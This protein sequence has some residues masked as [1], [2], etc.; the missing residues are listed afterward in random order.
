MLLAIDVGN[1]ETV[2]GVFRGEELAAHWRLSSTSPRTTDEV[3]ILFRQWAAE[4]NVVL[5]DMRGCVIS[6]VVPS[7]TGVFAEMARQAFSTEPVIIDSETETGL[8]VR[9][10]SPRT[11]G[12]DRICNA[13]AGF[14]RFGGPLIVVDFG[15][16]TTFDV[17]S[18][19]GEYL[20]GVIA[21][22]IKT[23]AQ[24]L[25]RVAAKLPKVDISFPE[26]VVG[27]DTETCMQSG[28]LW[29]TVAMVDGLIDRIA[30]EAGWNAVRAVGTGGL[31]GIVQSHSKR[32]ERVE[33]FLTLDGMRIIYEKATQ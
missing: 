17:I 9:I 23:A 20:G 30:L 7:L 12:A 24:G 33:P 10:D 16:A 6:S 29:G 32:I 28:I 13:V 1:S 18:E 19:R 2:L 27:R 5:S 8:V 31:A 21:L 26:S 22:G 3:R 4:A 14:A 15:T 11:L 25:H